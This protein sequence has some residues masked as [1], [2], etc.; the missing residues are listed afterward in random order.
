M[1]AVVTGIWAVPV[2]A[3]LMVGLVTVASLVAVASISYS[4]MFLHP[5]RSVGHKELTEPA[6]LSPLKGVYIQPSAARNYAVLEAEL[7]P[8]LQPPGR[9][10]LAFDKMA[11]LVLLLQGRPVG[12]AW[13]A[14]KER[15]R[16]AAGIEEACQHGQPWNPGRPP[17]ILLNRR[18][19]DVEITALRAC[20]LDFTADYEQLAPPQKTMNL[21]VYVPRNERDTKTP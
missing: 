5:Y 6:T 17:I 11:G 16:T 12:E 7:R 13:V 1:I 18:I 9:P 15:N 20:A 10:I 19:S 4:G 2:L 3:R 8:F 21:L 14:P